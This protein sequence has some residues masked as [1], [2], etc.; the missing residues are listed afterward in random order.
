[1]KFRIRKETVLA[2]FVFAALGTGQALPDSSVTPSNDRSA[3]PAGTPRS[4]AAVDPGRHL[5][6]DP[7]LVLSQDQS[8]ASCHSPHAAFADS[9]ALDL[10]GHK[11]WSR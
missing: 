8:C 7:R 2:A 1:M 11:E 6:F 5:F 4:D 9:V 3:W 10:T